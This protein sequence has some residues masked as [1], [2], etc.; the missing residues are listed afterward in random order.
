MYEPSI[1]T[2]CERHNN[3][4]TSS[5]PPGANAPYAVGGRAEAILK[6]YGIDS[7]MS[8]TFLYAVE[9]NV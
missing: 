6:A 9:C 3:E 7:P 4:S 5:F 8:A 2:V 1:R